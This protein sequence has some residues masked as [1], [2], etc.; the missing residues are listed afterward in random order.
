MC[1]DSEGLREDWHLYANFMLTDA[2]HPFIVMF[3][4]IALV[5]GVEDWSYY[6]FNDL[7]SINGPEKQ[8][9]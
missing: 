9:F 1:L 8:A 5:R 7:K 2:C 6:R 3:S 4:L